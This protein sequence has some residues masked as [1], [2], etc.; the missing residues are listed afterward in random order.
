MQPVGESR[1]RNT[2]DQ[3]SDAELAARVRGGEPALFELIMRRHNRRCSASRV[4]F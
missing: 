1:A 2:L 4:E 3:L